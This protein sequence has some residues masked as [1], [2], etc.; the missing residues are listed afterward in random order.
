MHGATHCLICDASSLRSYRAIFAPF[1]TR[2]VWN[3]VPFPI[4]L[5]ECRSCKFVFASPRFDP[6]EE[7]ALYNGYRKIEYQKVRQSCE[8]WYTDKFNTSLFS[9]EVLKKR[10]A[11][12]LPVLRQ[13]ISLDVKT[14]LDFGGDR[15]DLFDGFIPGSSTYVYDISGVEPVHDAKPLRS[16]AECSAH[17]FDLI[18]CSNVL[19]HVASPKDLMRDIKGIAS[20][21]T[22]LFVE[23]PS[24]TPFGMLTLTKR[25][26]QEVI[27]LGSRPG[28]AFP[29]L[30]FGFARQVHEHVNFFSLASLNTLMRLSGFEVLAS[31]SYQSEG[32]SF[33]LYKFAAGKMVW[34]IARP[35]R[36]SGFLSTRESQ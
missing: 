35:E 19:E 27:L 36:N 24:E 7:K 18:V 3:C 34:S 4:Q 20:A 6:Q 13:C 1:I 12:L 11:A 30:P 26:L 22:L 10:R 33:G 17:Q 23:V 25:L 16:L 29:M 21:G 28:V 31:G 5:L 9:A 14:I 2:R 15:G 32:F 8:P